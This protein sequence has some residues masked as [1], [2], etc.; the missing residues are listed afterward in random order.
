MTVKKASLTDLFNNS[1]GTGTFR[2]F[3]LALVLSMH[4]IGRQLLGTFGFEFPDQKKLTVAAEQ[5]TTVKQEITG[6]TQQM[7]EVRNDLS[8]IKANNAAFNT[9]VDLLDKAFQGFQVDFAKYKS[10]K[11]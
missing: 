3:M 9:K 5:A 7:L 11:K 1:F 6:L 10:D 2:T 4:P 8:M